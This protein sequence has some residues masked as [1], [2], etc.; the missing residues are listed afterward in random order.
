MEKEIRLFEEKLNTFDEEK[1]NPKEK[2][3]FKRLKLLLEKNVINE[4]ELK[5]KLKLFS[6]K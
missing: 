1:L 3:Y 4:K 2:N 5:Q 6:K